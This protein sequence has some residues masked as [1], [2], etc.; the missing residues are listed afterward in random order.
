MSFAYATTVEEKTFKQMVYDDFIVSG[1]N[2]EKC[3]DIA[4]IKTNDENYT[5]LSLH[6]EFLP[7]AKGKI[8]SITVYLNDANAALTT[9]Q[10]SNFLNDWARVFLPKGQLKEKN[11][12]KLCAKTSDVVVEVRILSDSK[13]GTYKT[14]DFSEEN[15]FTKTVSNTTPQIGEEIKVSV[16]LHNYGNEESFVTIRHFP[17]NAEMPEIEI[18]HGDTEKSGW[19]APGNEM[20]MEYYIKPKIAVRGKG[21]RKYQD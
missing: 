7:S 9:L 4:F 10:P 19:I 8:A 15:A 17:P 20:L 1:K 13:I 5:I 18:T 21:D 14:A 2:T 3:E 11:K 12:L 16:K 6:A